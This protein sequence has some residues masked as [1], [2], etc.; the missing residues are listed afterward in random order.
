MGLTTKS[1]DSLSSLASRSQ[2]S[3]CV[4]STMLLVVWHR[5]RRRTCIFCRE[6][7]R[8]VFCCCRAL[9]TELRQLAGTSI[10]IGRRVPAHEEA[11]S[12]EWNTRHSMSRRHRGPTTQVGMHA[13][14]SCPAG[15]RIAL[16]RS[17]ALVIWDGRMCENASI[18]HRMLVVH[19]TASGIG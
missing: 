5:K 8:E 12:T 13:H 17:S 18:E 16:A 2:V 3:P 1:L 10:G 14:V 9:A 11:P 19:D 15:M 4:F 7:S 6:T